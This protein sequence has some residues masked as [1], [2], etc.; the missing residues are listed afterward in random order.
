MLSGYPASTLD[1]YSKLKRLV[2]EDK[3]PVSLAWLLSEL[4]LPVGLIPIWEGREQM[5]KEDVGKAGGAAADSSNS[6]VLGVW[7]SKTSSC[8]ES[9]NENFILLD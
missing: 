8:Y 4:D 1:P 6:G 9:V 3:S 2:N 5:W 7:S